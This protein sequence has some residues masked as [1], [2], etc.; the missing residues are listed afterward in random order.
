[1]SDGRFGTTRFLLIIVFSSELYVGK[2]GQKQNVMTWLAPEPAEDF[3]G[4][5]YPLIE[6]LFTFNGDIYPSRSDYMGVL[7]LG[8]EAF[9][10]PKNVTFSVPKFS[11]DLKHT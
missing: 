1:M 4:D 9:S 11:I 5:L 3:T 8:S 7:Q 6:D 10:S 2:N